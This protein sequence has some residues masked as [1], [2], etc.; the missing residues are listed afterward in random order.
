MEEDMSQQDQPHSKKS[1]QSSTARA[2]IMWLAYK[3]SSVMQSK[4]QNKSRNIEN[5][6]KALEL[7]SKGATNNE[8]M[9]RQQEP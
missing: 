3:L 5:K 1:K 9:N 2:Q 4:H 8:R 7:E 6:A